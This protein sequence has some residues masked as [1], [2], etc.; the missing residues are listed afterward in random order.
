MLNVFELTAKEKEER[1]RMQRYIYE[2]NLYQ[3]GLEWCHERSFQ[4]E[5]IGDIIN[6]IDLMLMLKINGKYIWEKEKTRG[7]R[8]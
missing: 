7:K 1:D 4:D 3:R 2:R 8:D 5:H 6:E